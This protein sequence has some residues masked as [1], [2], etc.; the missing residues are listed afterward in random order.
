[1]SE[2]W[3]GKLILDDGSILEYVNGL[4]VSVEKEKPSQGVICTRTKLKQIFST[5]T[6]ESIDIFYDYWNDYARNFQI[7]TE[8]QENFFLTQVYAEVGANLQS[9]RENLNYSCDALKK[10]FKYYRE[11]PKDADKDGRCNGHP[12]DQKAIGN[13]AYGNRL[14]NG[15]VLTGD[16]YRFRG[17]GYFQLTGRTNYAMVA[18]LVNER[19]FLKDQT[20]ETVEENITLP[21]IGMLAA[22]AFWVDSKMYKCEHI[23]CCTAKINLYTDSYEKRKKY[24]QWIASIPAGGT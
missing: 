12:A 3:T 15:S 23:D 11:H 20:A 19:T 24:Y 5:A 16:G 7:L 8:M 1:M 17:G 22:L 14:G 18:E 9:V 10:T 21:S 2:L 4:L 13:Y 6:N